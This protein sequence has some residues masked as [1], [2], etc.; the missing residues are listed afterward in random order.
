MS[1]L[2]SIISETSL[3]VL[4]TILNDPVY[5]QAAHYTPYG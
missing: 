4:K 3:G 1:L 2:L 5:L